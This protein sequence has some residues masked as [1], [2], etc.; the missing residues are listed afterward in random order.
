MPDN[1]IYPLATA[2]N[3]SFFGGHRLQIN[4]TEPFIPAGQGEKYAA[5]HRVSDLLSTLTAEK[6][7]PVG[8]VAV[9]GQSGQ[10]LM[11]GTV[12]NN[13]I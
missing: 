8:N 2:R 12:A 1:F 9:A 3:H 4:A 10:T 5:S 13:V 7:N 11:F 6:T